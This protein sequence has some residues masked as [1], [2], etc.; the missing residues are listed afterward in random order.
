LCA[1]GVGTAAFNMQDIILEPYGGEI[2][3]LSVGDTTALTAILSFGA[4][5]AFAASARWLKHGIN[6]HRLSAAGVLIGI[7]AFSAVIFAAPLGSG[8][9]FRIGALL[10][11]FGGGLFAVSTLTVA[12]SLES[13][14]FVGLA[15]GA[16][17]AVQATAAGLAVAFGGALRDG[18]SALAQNGWLGSAL[19]SPATGYSFVYH[20]E[21]ALLFVTL[22]VIGPL[23]GAAD[24]RQSAANGFGLAEFPG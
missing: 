18:V 24:H 2:L 23:V 14:H 7:A 8:G 15:L 12:M 10:I 4:L 16:W 1:V 19:V 6:P 17:G 11:G 13:R 22:A 21:I 3:H 5:L 20:I 9:L